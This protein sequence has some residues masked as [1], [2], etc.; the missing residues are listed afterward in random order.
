M[1]LKNS[2]GLNPNEVEGRTGSE[3]AP[4]TKTILSNLNN[5]SGTGIPLHFEY[6]NTNSN[7]FFDISCFWQS[8]K[9][10]AGIFS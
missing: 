10:F 6:Y 5:S 1:H 7:K 3:I 4:F 8:K 9:K 2:A